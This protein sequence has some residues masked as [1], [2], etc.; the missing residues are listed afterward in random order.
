MNGVDIDF[1]AVT[2]LK[3]S[4]LRDLISADVD[5]QLLGKKLDP[6]HSSLKSYVDLLLLYFVKKEIPKGA[7]LLEI[8]GSNS[9]VLERLKNDYE[10]WNLDK[11]EGKFDGAKR[12]GKSQEGTKV[13]L[14]Y[15]GKFSNELP[16][17][18]FD[19]VFSNS[20]FEH[21][22]EGEFS[23]EDVI[24]DLKRV[25]KNSTYHF[26]TFDIRLKDKKEVRIY[27]LALN[28]LDSTHCVNRLPNLKNL[29]RDKDV[30]CLSE[31]FLNEVRLPF[32]QRRKPEMKEVKHVNYGRPTSLQLIW[33]SWK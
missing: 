28:L 22:R 15:I 23:F 2:F 18:Y 24:N 17:N 33:K 19:F 3:K 5:S 11:F 32:I 29:L 13:V 21:I 25:S 20:V 10:C 12:I 1:S 7:R 30:Y 31:K 8:G 14:D 26:H 16:L 6:N 9:R 4:L 27:E